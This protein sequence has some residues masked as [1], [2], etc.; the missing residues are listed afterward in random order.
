[1]YYYGFDIETRR[2]MFSANSLPSAQPGLAIL[3]DSEEL[4]ISEIELGM[5]L[6]GDLFIRTIQVP[7]EE[8]VAKAK[9][10]KEQML[11]DA[12]NR[13][14]ILCTVNK[15]RNDPLIAAK[16]AE[17]EAWIAAVYFIDVGDTSVSWPPMPELI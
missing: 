7:M 12:S 8:I 11:L 1:M 13:L 5:D 14:A 4:P 17:W 9:A 2:C 16:I 6:E 10:K 3:S 15:T